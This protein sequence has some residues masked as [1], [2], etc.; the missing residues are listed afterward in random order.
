VLAL[1]S[2]LRAGARAARFPMPLNE[3]YFQRLLRLQR[4]GAAQIEVWP[5]AMAPSPQAV[6][7]LRAVLAEAFG[8]R[9]ALQVADAVTFGAEDDAGL[10]PSPATTHAIA[11]FDLSATPEAESHGRFLRRLAGTVA[12]DAVV[13][14][15]VDEA[16]FKRRF[17]AMPER[18]AQRRDAW[19]L[20]CESLG[21]LPVFA[22]LEAGDPALIEPALQA[23]IARPVHSVVGP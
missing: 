20:F 10:Q 2:S 13:V 4:G 23:A 14:A 7:G 5:Y 1:L 16:A 18:L 17:D 12:S 8:A 9:V 11:W 3:S 22:D 6:L 21:T 19:R 15:L